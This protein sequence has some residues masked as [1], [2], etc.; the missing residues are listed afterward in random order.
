MKTKTT[1]T[2]KAALQYRKVTITELLVGFT[3]YI[4]WGTHS[5]KEITAGFT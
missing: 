3:K 5:R 2:K 4:K 1:T